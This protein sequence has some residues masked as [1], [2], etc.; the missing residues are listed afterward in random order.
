[1]KAWLPTV[2]VALL[3]AGTALAQIPAGTPDQPIGSRMQHRVVELARG[4]AHPWSLV[5]LPDGRLIISE[6][7]GGL[8]VF[9][10]GALL[11]RALS[12][13]PSALAKGDGGLLGLALDPQYASNQ[14]IYVCLAA[15]TEQ[16][17]ATAVVRAR[18]RGAALEDAKEI[19][20]AAP[21]KAKASHF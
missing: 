9:D 12:G 21:A 11:P 7:T 15:G 4:L 5:F 14:R 16:E 20:R 6:R 17:N 3:V 1:M 10:D 13:A 19:F 2:P 8:R 18:L